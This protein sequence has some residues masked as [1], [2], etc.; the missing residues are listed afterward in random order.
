MFQS[1]LRDWSAY[2]ISPVAELLL[3]QL[4]LHVL[5]AVLGRLRDALQYGRTGVAGLR[6]LCKAATAR[7]LT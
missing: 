6:R 3:A 7:Q 2:M 5:W 4:D 1:V